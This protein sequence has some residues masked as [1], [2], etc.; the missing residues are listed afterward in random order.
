M[1]VLRKGDSWVHHGLTHDRV[2]QWGAH[3]ETSMSKVSPL[4]SK[5]TK[6]FQQSQTFDAGESPK[7]KS[8]LTSG[9]QASGSGMNSKPETTPLET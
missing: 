4:N 6:S 1:A 5:R 8:A 7:P 2:Q 3:S 9:L